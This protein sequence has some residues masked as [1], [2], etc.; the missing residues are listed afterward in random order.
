MLCRPSSNLP[1]IQMLF[2]NEDDAKPADSTHQ[3]Q[4]EVIDCTGGQENRMVGRHHPRIRSGL[5]AYQ[6]I[7]TATMIV[8]P[9]K[10]KTSSLLSRKVL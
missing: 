8:I 1:I 5:I 10:P 6:V 4:W 2:H 9:I 7:S 3:V